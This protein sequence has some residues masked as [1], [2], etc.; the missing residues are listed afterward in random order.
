MIKLQSRNR[1]ADT[2]QEQSQAHLLTQRGP[3]GPKSQQQQLIA[4]ANY[5]VS[6]QTKALL[7]GS[8]P[9]DQRESVAVVRDLRWRCLRRGRGEISGVYLIEGAGPRRFRLLLG[10]SPS[11][12]Q[13]RET[14][15]VAQRFSADPRVRF[16]RTQNSLSRLA[17]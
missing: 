6:A 11:L 7:L 15:C 10:E 12:L 13:V 1:R 9:C 4:L 5:Y 16:G 3:G 2:A 8:L 14:A 17:S